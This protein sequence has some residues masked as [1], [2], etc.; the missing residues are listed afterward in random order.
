MTDRFGRVECHAVRHART[1]VVRLAGRGFVYVRR[2]TDGLVRREVELES[3]VEDGW[4]T[5]ADWARGAEV[6]VRGAQNVL[7]FELLGRQGEEQED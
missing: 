1:A 7:S 2:G 3:P 4:F 5:A 6:L